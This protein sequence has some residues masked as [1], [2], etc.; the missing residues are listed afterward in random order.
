MRAV[1]ARPAG[2]S[3]VSTVVGAILVAAILFALVVGVRVAYMPVWEE[4]AEAAHMET[5]A[6]ELGALRADLDRQAAGT[7]DVPLAHPLTLGRPDTNPLLPTGATHQL[8]FV[9][10]TSW[11]NLSASGMTVA[12]EDGVSRVGANESWNPVA[13]N[14]SIP[15]VVSLDHF[16]VRLLSVS[17]ADAGDSFVLTLVNGSGGYRGDINLSVRSTGA[18][19]AFHVT[20]RDAAGATLVD[21]PLAAGLD[22]ASDRWVDMLGPDTGLRQLLAAAQGPLELRLQS[23]GLDARY[24][25]SFVQDTG[26]SR[27]R[28]GGGGLEVSSWTST[29][30]G[31]TLV[32]RGLNTRF[33]DQEYRLEN[34]AL[35]LHQGEGAI[36]DVGPTFEATRAGDVL[37]IDLLLPT[38]RGEAASVGGSSLATLRTT[39]TST[40][41]VEGS[42]PDLTLRVQSATPALWADH[43]NATLAAVPGLSAGVHY[44]VSTG[45]GSATLTVLGLD[46]AGATRDIELHLR[47]ADVRVEV[48]A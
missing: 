37:R 47:Q 31:G 1:P 23:H 12:T 29:H 9:P 40:Y 18:T 10:H 43:W 17:A 35:G 2:D 6:H 15:G 27:T 38:L 3:A 36:F 20:A 13:G 44:T 14:L 5:V 45:A 48:D 32:Y 11:F 41:H 22:A 28:A 33:V 16:R 25:A 7:L 21:Q 34:G 19:Y 26:G 30:Q 8:R 39:T 4:R 46:P 24:A 42:A